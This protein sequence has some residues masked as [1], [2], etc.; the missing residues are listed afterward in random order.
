M[1]KVIFKGAA[2]AIVTPFKSD[3]EIDKKSFARLI[4]F[5]IENGIDAIVVCGTTGEASTMPDEE[6]VAAAKF[7]VDYVAGRV[8]VIAG[9]GSN[10][11]RHGV[12]L[13]KKLEQTGAD[14]LLCVTPYYNKTT[15]EGLFQHFKRTAEAVK[16]DIL[17]Y[18]VPSRTGLNINPETLKRLCELPNINGLK[19]CNL[20]QIPDVVAACRDNLN[21]YSG[22][23]GYVQFMMSAGGC[24]VISV[25]A[26]VMPAY[27]HDMVKAYLDGDPARSLKMQVDA[28]PLIKA[29]FCEVNPIPVKEAL[30]MMGFAVGDPR[31]PLVTMMPENREKLR[32]QLKAFGL[33]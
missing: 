13:A 9:G 29:L 7:C 33:I 10:D 6:H 15:Q 20:L 11:T 24:G 23:D 1:K 21:L 22:E 8:P 26:N 4:D 30:N 5:Q 14:A 18:N 32:T 19:E 3:T 2:S 31:M 16:T 12:E 17:L 28:L 25:L 27:T